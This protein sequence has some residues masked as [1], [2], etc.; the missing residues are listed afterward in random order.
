MRTLLRRGA[1]AATA[2]VSVLTGACLD[3]PPAGIGTIDAAVG[4]DA[5][6]SF[7]VNRSANVPLPD[8]GGPVEDELEVQPFAPSPA[9]P[10]T[11][12]SSTAFEA[13]S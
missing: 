13:T 12:T 10:W 7:T 8:Q 3:A 4:L 9:S 5:A 6:I 2:T 1:F 11:S